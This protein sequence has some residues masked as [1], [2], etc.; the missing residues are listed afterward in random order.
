MN[1]R[2]D[3]FAIV[4]VAAL[5]RLLWLSMPQPLTPDGQEYLTLARALH[6]Q[7]FFTADGASP[8]NYRPPL[9]PLMIAFAFHGQAPPPLTTGAGTNSLWPVYL[10]QGILGTLTAALTYLIARRTFTRRVGLLAGIGVAFA[11]TI[12]RYSSALLTETLFIFLVVAAIWQW[13]VERPIA[14]GILFGLATLTRAMLWPFF[15]ALAIGSYWMPSGLSRTSRVMCLAASLVVAPW[16]ARNIVMTGNVTI[17]STGW[18]GSLLFG[19]VP[20][21]RGS[22]T[23]TQLAESGRRSG[24]D[25]V[26]GERLARQEALRIIRQDPLAW[27]SARVSQWPGL[28]LDAGGSIPTSANDRSF[29]EAFRQRAWS[30]VMFKAGFMLGNAVIAVAALAGLFLTRTRWAESVPVWSFPV[31]LCVAHLPMYVE[32][33]YGLP[34]VP[35]LLIYAAVAVEHVGPA[36]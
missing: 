21:H 9:Y 32:P 1:D 8:S 31:Y 5:V 29:S 3:L 35:F 14:A 2:R 17:A 18:G 20:L 4:T 22:N 19:T 24:A 25:L 36:V 30:T 26:E 12:A 6:A 15:V 23:W 33:R 28:F 13:I 7:H 11:P 10:L 16:V 27:L 34:L